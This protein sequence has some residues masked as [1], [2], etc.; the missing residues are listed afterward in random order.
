MTD[1]ASALLSNSALLLAI[2]DPGTALT[3]AGCVISSSPPTAPYGVAAVQALLAS[4]AN[5]GGGLSCA[6]YNTL[7]TNGQIITGPNNN[8]SQTQTAVV[9]GAADY[10]LIPQSFV[11]SPGGNDSNSWFTVPK[12]AHTPIRQWAVILN[13]APA[14][15]QVLAQK[16]LDYLTSAAG[17]GV[18]QQFGYDPIS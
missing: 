15:D 1:L 18:L 5:G 4:P 16:F 11:I 14:A 3:L 9:S 7:V 13:T 10:A 12:T 6:Q 2:P 8:V 17:Q